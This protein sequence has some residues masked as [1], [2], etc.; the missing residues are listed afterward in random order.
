MDFDGR[1]CLRRGHADRTDYSGSVDRS[2]I[3]ERD[4]V[5]ALIPAN[6]PSQIKSSMLIRSGRFAFDAFKLCPI[7][8]CRQR[9]LVFALITLEL[10]LGP[11]PLYAR[12]R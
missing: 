7:R 3:A 6:S 4:E 9:F 5:A 8:R 2:R 10:G 11:L 1:R 12:K